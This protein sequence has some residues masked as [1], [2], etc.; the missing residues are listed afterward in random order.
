MFLPSDST[1]V[2]TDEIVEADLSFDDQS[3]TENPFSNEDG[4]NPLPNFPNR[5]AAPKASVGLNS[6]ALLCLV[7]QAASGKH[8]QFTIKTHLPLF[9]TSLLLPAVDSI[10]PSKQVH[11]ASKLL[12]IKKKIL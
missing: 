2:A 7:F 6:E 3:D 9:T 12:R 1:C 10:H 11:R 4:F 8:S 5:E